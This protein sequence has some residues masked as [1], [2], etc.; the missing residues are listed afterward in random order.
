VQAFKPYHRKRT[1][2]PIQYHRYTVK[3]NI[4]EKPTE[5]NIQM[6]T[7]IKQPGEEKNQTLKPGTKHFWRGNPSKI[8]RSRIY[9]KSKFFK[10]LP[11]TAKAKYCGSFLF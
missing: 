8:L 5:F 11:Q 4:E 3:G 6:S 9:L 1:K 2:K 7:L 10:K